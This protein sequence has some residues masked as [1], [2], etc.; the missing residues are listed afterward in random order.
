MGDGFIE[1]LEQ[2]AL[3]NGS[4]KDKVFEVLMFCFEALN[5]EKYT[6]KEQFFSVDTFLDCDRL[7]DIKK[8]SKVVTLKM[9]GD[10]MEVYNL[11]II[12]I[13]IKTYPIFLA[14]D[15][16]DLSKVMA[17]LDQNLD[18]LKPFVNFLNLNSSL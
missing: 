17:E 15:T 9:G 3:P 12:G 8:I 14:D 18:F 13:F 6:F 4:L 2:L 1:K 11:A 5:P 16:P 7:S 10:F